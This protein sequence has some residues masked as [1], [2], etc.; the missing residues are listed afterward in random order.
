MPSRRTRKPGCR[1]SRRQDSR[2]PAWG[3]VAVEPAAEVVVSSN[4]D[5]R[6]IVGAEV[7]VGLQFHG[8]DA[9]VVAPGVISVI[10]HIVG[11]EGEFLCLRDVDDFVVVALC[12]ALGSKV[13]PFAGLCPRPCGGEQHDEQGDGGTPHTCAAQSPCLRCHGFLGWLIDSHNYHRF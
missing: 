5:G 1:R 6:P 8:E 7:D 4:S 13:L 12:Q 3:P 9:V 11:I 2:S 10:V